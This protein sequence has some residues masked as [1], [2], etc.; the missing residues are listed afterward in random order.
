MIK[1]KK[2]TH[3]HFFLYTKFCSV[4]VSKTQICKR[5]IQDLPEFSAEASRLRGT[6]IHQRI[7]LSTNKLARRATWVPACFPG[8]REAKVRVKVGATQRRAAVVTIPSGWGEVRWAKGEGG[9][10][11][12]GRGLQSTCSSP[13]I[14]VPLSLTLSAHSLPHPSS[15][16]LSSTHLIILL[17]PYLLSLL[18]ILKA[19]SLHPLPSYSFLSFPLP[20]SNSNTLSLRSPSSSSYLT[21]HYVPSLPS[22]PLSVSLPLPSLL[23]KVNEHN[24]DS[25]HITEITAAE[26]T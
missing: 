7:S 4:H 9:G 12:T 23:R 5:F 13:P 17:L 26:G 20:D 19:S 11:A 6:A 2:N 16:H 8:P 24:R 14:S 21:H 1:E 15:A 18:Q 10:D 3:A 25:R 22:P